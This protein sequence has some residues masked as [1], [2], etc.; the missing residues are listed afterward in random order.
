MLSGYDSYCEESYFY[1]V[2]AA[3]E[4]GFNAVAFDGPGQGQC[5][6]R[7]RL[8]FR[9]D[10]EAVVSPVLDFISDLPGVDPERMFLVGRSFAGYLAPR[11]AAF[12]RRVAALVV[13]PGLMDLGQVF[14]DRLPSGT[15]EAIVQGNGSQVDEGFEALFARDEKTAFFFRSRM[16]AHGISRVSEYIQEMMGY[17]LKG[18]AEKIACPTLITTSG[19][20]DPMQGGQSK[21]LYDSIKGSKEL[22]RF[23]A[24]EGAGDH[25]EAG[26][27]SLFYQRV[28]DRLD[29]LL[30][31]GPLGR[32]KVAPRTR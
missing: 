13:D 21:E 29:V 22:I 23:S 20:D 31:A 26:A 10:W 12:D 27:P 32:E 7:Q 17:N 14:K 25:C 30:R 9:P 18:V 24:E 3:L 6:R 8:Y 15:L 5:L 4:R 19:G 28:F 2:R 16:A 11:A 1:F